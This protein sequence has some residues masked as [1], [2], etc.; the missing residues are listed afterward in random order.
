MGKAVTIICACGQHLG[1]FKSGDDHS[2]VNMKCPKCGHWIRID[3]QVLCHPQYF[4]A[5]KGGETTITLMTPPRKERPRF[6]PH[7]REDNRK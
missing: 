7:Q 3:N 6:V 1:T 2:G 4:G 5:K